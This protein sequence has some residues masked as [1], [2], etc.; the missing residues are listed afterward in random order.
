MAQQPLLDFR[1]GETFLKT[2]VEIRTSIRS[3]IHDSL[4]IEMLAFMAEVRG[5]L[6]GLAASD[7]ASLFFAIML[8]ENLSPQSLLVRRCLERACECQR[9]INELTYIYNNISTDNILYKLTL[10]QVIRYG[11]APRT[12]E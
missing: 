3:Q 7:S 10:P 1:E 6:E 4:M 8:N 12:G 11:L 5:E 9:E 2:G